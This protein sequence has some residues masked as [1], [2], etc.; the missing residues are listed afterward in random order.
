MSVHLSSPVPCLCGGL[1]S[2]FLSLLRI[3]Q[4]RER[5]Q[6]S[7][8]SPHDP[9]TWSGQTRRNCSIR[10]ACRINPQNAGKG[11]RRQ[12]TP[13]HAVTFSW[14]THVS[15]WWSKA[16][17]YMTALDTRLKTHCISNSP[18]LCFNFIRNDSIFPEKQAHIYYFSLLLK[19]FGRNIFMLIPTTMY[20]PK[21]VS[22]RVWM[23]TLGNLVSHFYTLI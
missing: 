6:M 11:R 21:V 18:N 12:C 2:H 14:N 23:F 15:W 13:K 20:S 22:A 17:F 5:L 16:D 4:I 9:V 3:S 19:T 7:S 8:V 1:I 10:G